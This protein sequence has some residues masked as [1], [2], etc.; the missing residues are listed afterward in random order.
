[1]LFACSIPACVGCLLAR[2]VGLGLDFGLTQAES[3]SHFLSLVLSGCNQF[4][5][6]GLNGSSRA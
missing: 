5:S 1:M 4:W 2:D 3:F 6:V